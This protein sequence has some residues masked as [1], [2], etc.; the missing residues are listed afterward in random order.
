MGDRNF[1][2]LRLPFRSSDVASWEIPEHPGTKRRFLN[3]KIIELNGGFSRKPWLITGGY[4]SHRDGRVEAEKLPPSD[5]RKD[6]SKPLK[7]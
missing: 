5:S 6:V 4:A 1:I 3:R 7:L 2:Y